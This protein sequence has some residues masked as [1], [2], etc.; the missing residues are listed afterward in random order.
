MRLCLSGLT[1]PNEY[2]SSMFNSCNGMNAR[3]PHPPN[4]NPKKISPQFK[5][6]MV[7]LNNNIKKKLMIVDQKQYLIIFDKKT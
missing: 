7:T 6:L 5:Y 3:H 2:V 4:R 1:A